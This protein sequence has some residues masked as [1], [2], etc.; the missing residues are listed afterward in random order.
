M[1]VQLK[2]KYHELVIQFS[3][4]QSPETSLREKGVQMAYVVQGNGSGYFVTVTVID[5]NEDK[6]TLEYE[7][8]SADEAAALAA[9]DD[10][11]VAL[12]N[13]SQVRVI[14][15]NLQKRF[16]NDTPTIPA[17]GE[18]QVKARI[19]FKLADGREYGTFDVPAPE[20]TAFLT[21]TGKGNKI[22]DITKPIVTAYADLFKATGVAFISDGE[23]LETI[24]EGRKVSSRSG[25][26][27]R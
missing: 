3:F 23:S 19:A 15:Y 14:G 22:V 21:A 17:A 25:F 16:Y 24:S 10:I 18:I 2:L 7:L 8:R 9:V 20:E 5:R 4:L 11:I 27:S 13:L 26:R 6:A 12:T 1:T